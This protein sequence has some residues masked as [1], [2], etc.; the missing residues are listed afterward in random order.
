MTTR[1]VLV[2]PVA[3]GDVTYATEDA[4]SVF[5]VDGRVDLMRA[6][7]VGRQP[8]RNERVLVLDVQDLIDALRDG[9]DE[10][11]EFDINGTVV[12]KSKKAVTVQLGDGRCVSLPTR[13]VEADVEDFV[14]VARLPRWLALDRGL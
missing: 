4:I 10:L 8:E 14:R 9:D 2:L 11:A 13:Y 1:K 7:I 3:L 6:D 5:D 12:S